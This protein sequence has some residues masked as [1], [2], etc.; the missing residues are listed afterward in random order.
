MKMQTWYKIIKKW[1]NLFHYKFKKKDS[2]SSVVFVIAKCKWLQHFY[3]KVS[4]DLVQGNI[5]IT[6]WR[7][8]FVPY[9][10]DGWI[11]EVW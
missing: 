4:Q 11:E 6:K 8:A 3:Y 10:Q 2:G 1:L 5:G 7:I 9:F